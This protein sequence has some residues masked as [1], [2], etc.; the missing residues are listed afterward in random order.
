MVMVIFMSMIISAQKAIE[1]ANKFLET[2]GIVACII[3]KTKD[4]DKFWYIEASAFGAILKLQVNKTTGD[5]EN[6]KTSSESKMKEL[7]VRVGQSCINQSKIFLKI[8]KIMV[9]E[10]EFN[11]A[12]EMYWSAINEL[13]KIIG[14]MY[15]KAIRNHEEMME[16][17]KFIALIK[18][19]K[20][21]KD[22]IIKS[23]Q[24]L[25]VNF[26]ENFLDVEVFK[27]HQEKVLNAYNKF[28]KIILE[29]KLNDNKE[30]MNS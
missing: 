6:Y 16:L 22:G 5:V 24:L 3:T 23:A 11:E 30:I 10:Q 13:L 20:D 15:G 28:Y 2:T 21:L 18:K 9:K 8:A 1:I 17:A 12:G 7:E 29:S 27:E 25:H 19:D 4:E 26:Y 14:L